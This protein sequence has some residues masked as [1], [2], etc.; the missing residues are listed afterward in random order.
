[1]YATVRS[2]SGNQ[3]LAAAIAERESDVRQVISTIAG[4]RAYYLIRG[5]DG[6]ATTISVF[7][8]QSGA[9]ES[10]SAAAAYI[11]DNMADLS[12]S[13][14]QVTAGEVLISF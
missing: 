2:Y 11:R 8:D 5:A 6:E 7:D 13:P 14:P 9:E 3:D 12:V 1:M 10:N 4:F